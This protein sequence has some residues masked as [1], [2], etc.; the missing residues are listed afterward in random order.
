[1][2]YSPWGRKESDM[3]ERLTHTFNGIGESCLFTQECFQNSEAEIHHWEPRQ[4]GSALP[5]SGLLWSL[6]EDDSP[7]KEKEVKRK[8]EKRSSMNFTLFP[9]NIG[10]EPAD[11]SLV[12]STVTQG[13]GAGNI[14]SLCLWRQVVAQAWSL[15]GVSEI[16]TGSRCYSYGRCG[17]PNIIFSSL[18]SLA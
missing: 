7:R 12:P 9:S 10:G 4:K 18:S 13:R 1:M 17:H 16:I 6:L 3:T 14:S 5:S 2:G 8:K 11:G 15:P